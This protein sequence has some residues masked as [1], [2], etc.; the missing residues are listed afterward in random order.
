MEA[1][2]PC[3]HFSTIQ[4][5]HYRFQPKPE[6]DPWSGD[7]T[8]PWLGFKSH[9][10][11]PAASSLSLQIT[12][13]RKPPRTIRQINRKWVEDHMNERGQRTG[14]RRVFCIYITLTGCPGRRK[15]SGGLSSRWADF[16]LG[17]RWP[18]NFP[19]STPHTSGLTSPED[20]CFGGHRLI[21]G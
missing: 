21:A 17:M 6:E 12:R 8:R 14:S 4:L 18:G 13:R 20:A 7:N 15:H 1:A 10:H 11:D 19:H 3:F 9:R 2:R 16:C 5:Y